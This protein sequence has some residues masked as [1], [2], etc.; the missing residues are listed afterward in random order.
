MENGGGWRL[1]QNRKEDFL[2]GLAMAIKK[3]PTTSI[4][5]HTNE[6]KVHE[7]NV[8]VFEEEW[9]KTSEE[10]ILKSCKSFSKAPWYNNWKKKKKWWRPYWV[11]F[12]VLC[13]S[14]YF[15]IYFL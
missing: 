12:P 11:K 4:R 6:L 7:K 9:N 8:S 1:N 13:L 10:F 3:D 2:T 14:S 15:L 5:K